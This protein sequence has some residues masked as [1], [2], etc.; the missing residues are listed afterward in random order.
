MASR[1]DSLF[2]TNNN[3]RDGGDHTTT[4]DSDATAHVSPTMASVVADVLCLRLYHRKTNALLV[5]VR[6]RT[7]NLSVT[8]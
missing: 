7:T 1:L 3:F 2:T 6:V 5:V 8:V 4:T